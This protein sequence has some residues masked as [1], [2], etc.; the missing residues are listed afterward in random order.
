[1]VDLSTFITTTLINTAII[2]VILMFLG[3]IF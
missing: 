2:A 3:I 1:M